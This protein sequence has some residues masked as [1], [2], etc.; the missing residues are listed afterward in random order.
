MNV[1]EI[2]QVRWEYA[3]IS[4]SEV[5]HQELDFEVMTGLLIGEERG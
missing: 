2:P 3:Y 1:P 5:V 4:V